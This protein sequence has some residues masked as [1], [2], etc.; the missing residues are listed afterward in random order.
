MHNDIGTSNNLQMYP[1]KGQDWLTESRIRYP[2]S[3]IYTIYICSCY[4]F[5]IIQPCSPFLHTIHLSAFIPFNSCNLSMLVWFIDTK[6]KLQDW[7]ETGTHCFL[8]L[9]WKVIIQ[10]QV[11]FWHC[12]GVHY[13]KNV[14]L[15]LWL[16]HV[17]KRGG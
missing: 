8:L 1:K 2:I 13:I 9:L 6:V 17:C 11:Y 16:S 10:F 12:T 4:S 7:F 3:P 15:V 14:F 5:K